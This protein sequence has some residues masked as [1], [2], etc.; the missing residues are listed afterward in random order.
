MTNER[1]IVLRLES[2]LSTD[3]VDLTESMAGADDLAKKAKAENTRRAYKAAWQVFVDWCA[4]KNLHPLPAEAETL[5]IYIYE[6]VSGLVP[7]RKLKNAKQPPPKARR[8]STVLGHLAAI[9]HYHHEYGVE[10]QRRHPR[11]L[12]EID[13]AMR[14]YL[15][16]QRVKKEPVL[17]SMLPKI[18]A[19]IA[20][21]PT[22]IR[23]RFMV[24]LGFGGAF[25]CS[26][27]MSTI[28]W[29]DIVEDVDGLRVW[30]TKG[31]RDQQ[32]AGREIQISKGVRPE[33]CVMLALSRWRDVMKRMRLPTTGDN[34]IFVS[35]SNNHFGKALGKGNV[36]LVVKKAVEIAGYDPALYAA[37]SLR[38]GWITSALLAG[39]PIEIVRLKPGH[40]NTTTTAGYD[41]R[42][43][44]FENDPG[45][46]LM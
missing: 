29:K 46:G 27:Y 16:K 9:R 4:T 44:S 40:E 12:D 18:V 35:L 39:H 13:G 6:M 3:T 1:E 7:A 17:S 31:K 23:D 37:H 43:H 38:S 8:P 36:A 24:L 32:G 45:K 25:R 30:L 42:K 41:R 2:N 5:R 26:D 21:T 11:V 15:G 10:S 28:R 14:H 34:P 33:T 19:A 20:N 22:G